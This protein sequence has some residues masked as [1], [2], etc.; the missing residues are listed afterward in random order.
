[1]GQGLDWV[2]LGGGEYP[3]W[4]GGWGGGEGWDV[5]V[6]GQAQVNLARTGQAGQA[7]AGMWVAIGRS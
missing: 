3:G 7:K 5:W 4:V 6:K 1:M 2:G